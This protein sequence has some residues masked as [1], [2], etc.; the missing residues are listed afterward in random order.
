[1]LHLVYYQVVTH[2]CTF[3]V[4]HSQDLH[5][6]A[7][8]R[9]MSTGQFLQIKQPRIKDWWFGKRYAHS[10]GFMERIP[11]L[12][13]HIMRIAENTATNLSAGACGIKLWDPVASGCLQMVH[14]SFPAA[15]QLMS[16]IA[17]AVH[18]LW[19]QDKHLSCKR[20]TRL[21]S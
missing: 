15:K 4:V 21:N 5:P 20:H 8:L 12:Q 3:T 16:N 17:S 7:K 11:S 10:A 6:L 2:S 18:E 1:M 13:D 19:L 14:T 9:H